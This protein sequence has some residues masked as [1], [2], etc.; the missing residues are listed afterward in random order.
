[1]LK[2]KTGENKYRGRDAISDEIMTVEE[3][4]SFLGFSRSK[5]YKMAQMDEIPAFKVSRSWRFSRSDIMKWLDSLN[6]AGLK[7][8][9]EQEQNR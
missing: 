8:A 9:P 1:M 7:D 6:T 4:S 3:V 2:E 5:I